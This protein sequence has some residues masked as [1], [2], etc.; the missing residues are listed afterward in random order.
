MS[1]EDSIAQATVAAVKSMA[2]GGTRLWIDIHDTDAEKLRTS[3]W[4]GDQLGVSKLSKLKETQNNDTGHY[5]Q[6]LIANGFFLQPA[7]WEA[8]GTSEEY[9]KWLARQKS[10]LSNEYT[11]Y[12][13]NN[14]GYCDPAHY[15]KVNKGAGTGIKP[16]YW[17][18]PLTH[19]EHRLSHQDGDRAI[20][21]NEWWNKKCA[22]YI[23]TWAGIKLK[24]LFNVKSRK[25]INLAEF[26]EWC[27]SVEVG[28][29][30][31]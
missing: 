14:E 5:W 17:G 13:E 22:H 27:Y 11:G 30:A 10:A 28:I 19:Q 8:L 9:F 1:V 23:Q 3:V 25:E 7:L 6:R 26:K 4:V 16:D 20:G 2:D 29:D 31:S 18:I 12:N 21:T 24:Q 15:R